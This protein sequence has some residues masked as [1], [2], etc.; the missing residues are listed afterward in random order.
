MNRASPSA[1]TRIPMLGFGHGETLEMLHDTV[2]AFAAAEMRRWLI[3]REL[4]AE[5]AQA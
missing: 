3:G 1:L 4:F 5:T 2:R